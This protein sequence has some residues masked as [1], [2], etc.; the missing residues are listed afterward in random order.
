MKYL[1]LFF[2]VIISSCNYAQ[3]DYPLSIER[4]ERKSKELLHL[5][6]DRTVYPIG[7]RGDYLVYQV[8]LKNTAADKSEPEAYRKVYYDEKSKSIVKTITLKSVSNKI[9]TIAQN[10]NTTLYRGFKDLPPNYESSSILD[11]YAIDNFI[12]RQDFWIEVDGEEIK[13]I[14]F[15]SHYYD[16]DIETNIDPSGKIITF[17]TFVSEYLRSTDAD[18]IITVFK[19]KDSGIL[20]EELIC[21]SCINSQVNNNY[22]FYGKKFFYMQ[23]AGVYDFSIYKAPQYELEKSELI[24][25]YAEIVKISPE[26]RYI[27]AKKFFYGKSTYIILD[28][29]TKK[30]TYLL[31]RDYMQYRCFYSP[32]YKRF[33]FD[34]G[35]NIIYI[36]YPKEFPFNSLGVDAERKHTS[37]EQDRVFWEKH[38]HADL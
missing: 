4:I 34:T 38:K 36:D 37:N 12:S 5:Q 17:N 27:L 9:Y 22:I 7:W 6:E 18:S 25:E 8:N 31:G 30:F 28:L 16:K 23:G 24:M 33:A 35:D 1:I 11:L 3:S 29:E 10:Q 20:K 13:L 14:T 26:G 21:N 2:F 19:I 32:A 15:P